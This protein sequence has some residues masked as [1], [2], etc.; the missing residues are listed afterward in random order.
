MCGHNNC[1]IVDHLWNSELFLTVV[2]LVLTLDTDLNVD[3]LTNLN[4]SMSDADRP[5]VAVYGHHSV[6]V[7][8]SPE[9]ELHR[10]QAYA[11]FLPDIALKQ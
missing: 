3:S 1:L 10:H 5:I 4:S 8:D 9:R 11:S 6:V 7:D 2:K